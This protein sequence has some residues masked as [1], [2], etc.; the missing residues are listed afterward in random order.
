MPES[1]PYVSIEQWGNCKRCGAHQDLRCGVCFE[2]SDHVRGERISPTTHK[3]W[4]ADNPQNV[5]YY[6]ETGH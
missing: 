4:D 5:W 2:C 1:K 6:S 3:L